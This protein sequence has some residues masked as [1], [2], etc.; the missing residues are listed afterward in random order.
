M[1]TNKKTMKGF[2][3]VSGLSMILFGICSGLVG[4]YFAFQSWQL[5]SHGVQVD[6][7]VV[8]LIHS[9]KG[10]TAAPVYEYTIDGETYQYRSKTKTNPYPS[11]GDHRTLVVDPK[12][13]ARAS[14]NDF[15]G[16]WLLPIIACPVSIVMIV[17]AALVMIVGNLSRKMDISFSG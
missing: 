8:D 2:N 15:T 1:A 10:H 9:S 6:A 14:E 17:A 13:P 5:V 4:I 16:L 3:I 7:V 12:N 11:I